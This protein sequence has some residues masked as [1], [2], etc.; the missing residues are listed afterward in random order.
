MQ[1]LAEL[2]FLVDELLFEPDGSRGQACAK[3]IYLHAYRGADLE[4]Y[5]ERLRGGGAFGDAVVRRNVGWAL[6]V[7]AFDRDDGALVRALLEGDH[8]LD[9]LQLD[10]RRRVGPH[11]IAAIVG[12][13][14]RSVDPERAH[15]FV[16]LY[17]LG[18]FEADLTPALPVL[19]DALGAPA[20]GRGHRRVDPSA[21]AV[22][23]LKLVARASSAHKAA[24]LEALAR[25]AEG[26]GKPAAAARA[27]A[28]EVGG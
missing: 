26:R 17:R 15:A 20:V 12:Y 10:H 16:A 2:S 7:W 14:E 22:G 8:A 18:Q 24:L 3:Q 5:V 23:A 1:E 19:L 9:V 6:A 21:L 25:R 11:V 28:E 13:A 4:P 27:L